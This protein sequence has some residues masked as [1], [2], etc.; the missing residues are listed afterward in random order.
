MRTIELS[1]LDLEMSEVRNLDCEP[2]S[3]LNRFVLW[4]GSGTRPI[5][6]ARILFPSMED[7]YLQATKSLRAYAWNK[8]TAMS[9]RER[10]EIITATTYE[11]IC[12]KIYGDLPDYTKW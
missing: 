8:I 6:A 12:D 10:G 4:I 9:L 11:N 2:L 3:N 7:G 5:R 1:E